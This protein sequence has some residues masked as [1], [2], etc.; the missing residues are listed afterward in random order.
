MIMFGFFGCCRCCG[1]CRNGRESCGNCGRTCGTCGSCP[2]CPG[3]PVPVPP[4][5]PFPPTP[6]FTPAS[7][8]T[9]L[10][11]SGGQVLTVS[12]AAG[13]STA[14]ALVGGTS[15]TEG[16]AFGSPVALSPEQ[17]AVAAIVPAGGCVRSFT[18][19]WI[20]SAPPLGA[21]AGRMYAALFADASGNGVYSLVPGSLTRLSGV[22]DGTV[23]A[24]NVFVG[25]SR[26]R[27]VLTA[28]SRL[29]TMF[30]MLDSAGNAALTGY[31]SAALTL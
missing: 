1:K 5:P 30:Y 27:S 23:T 26:P 17:Q 12:A 2:V 7:P 3:R 22:V 28:G 9:L 29:L 14:S 15:G 8:Y 20:A 13:A 21:V 31:G 18:A 19:S 10:M 4:L 16:P 11:T 6:P 25:T 24:G